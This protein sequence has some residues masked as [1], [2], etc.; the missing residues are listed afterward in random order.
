MAF[1]FRKCKQLYGR[2]PKKRRPA[3]N[4]VDE[5]GLCPKGVPIL[6]SENND[7]WIVFQHLVAQKT[8]SNTGIVAYDADLVKGIN[9]LFNIKGYS[10]VRLSGKIF[11]MV[12]VSNALRSEKLEKERNTKGQP[13]ANFKH[14]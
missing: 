8:D 13:N 4:K 10:A 11:H 5:E 12:D 2:L 7:A 9:D 3:C 14:R 6:S 1:N